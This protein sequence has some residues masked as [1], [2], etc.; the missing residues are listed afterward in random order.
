MQDTVWRKVSL[1]GNIWSEAWKAWR[2]QLCGNVEDKCSGSEDWQENQCYSAE[3]ARE[4][5]IS[6]D[7]NE[8]ARR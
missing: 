7:T 1:R 4:T 3:W 6:D 2:S 5:E 8:V